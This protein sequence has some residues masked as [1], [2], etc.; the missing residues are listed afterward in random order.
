MARIIDRQVHEMGDVN[1]FALTHAE[2]RA[3]HN[4][5]LQQLLSLEI[6]GYIV[7]KRLLRPD[8]TPVWVRSSVSLAGNESPVA[9]QLL[10]ICED[11]SERKHGEQ[12]LQ[13]QE[14]MA[15]LGRLTS[16]IVH[17]INN[18]LE[19]VFN[20]IYLARESKTLDQARPYLQAAE[21]ELTRASE[22][23]TQALQ[24]HRQTSV[25]QMA[26]VMDILQNVLVL[27]RGKLR[28]SEVEVK[29]DAGSA[30][31]LL[32]LPGELRQ[33]FANLI[34][35]AIDSMSRGG[36]LRIRVR[37][38]TDWRTGDP[39]VRVT[40][41]DT[42][43]GMSKETRKRLYDAF[44]TTK[45]LSGS[46]LGMWVT[47]NIV[48]KHQGSVHVRSSPGGTAFTLMFPHRGI[49]GRISGFQDAA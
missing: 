25:A 2:D 30:P 10:H 9:G 39:G 7:E 37:S 41:A 44:Y 35:N 14:Q 29:L 24:F 4:E 40:I 43:S 21:E 48:R 31:A 11:I 17:E 15:A 18:P 36:V 28:R 38:G 32:C 19:A 5:L 6:P 49:E 33:V 46:G 45:G 42:G 3:M 34:G 1:L 16:S 13:R 27:L 26:N 23:T 12:I 8:G 22:I 47:A 20:L